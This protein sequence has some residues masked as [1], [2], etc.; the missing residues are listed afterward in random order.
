MSF[1]TKTLRVE[2]QCVRR[3]AVRNKRQYNQIVSSK[4]PVLPL[5]WLPSLFN[6]LA[7]TVRRA[8]LRGANGRVFGARFFS[9]SGR[10]MGPITAI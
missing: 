7:K 5:L 8:S 6:A 9:A 1:R 10:Y 3:C 4:S 2:T